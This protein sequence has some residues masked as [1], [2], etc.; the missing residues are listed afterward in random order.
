MIRVLKQSDIDILI[1]L[2]KTIRRNDKEELKNI[3][4]NMGVTKIL[5]GNIEDGKLTSM[6]VANLI[7]NNYYLEDIIFL[8]NDIDEV[9]EVMEYMVHTLKEDERGLNILYDNIPYSEVMDS[10]MVNLGFKCDYINFVS[11]ENGRIEL[12]RNHIVINDISED[13]NKYMLKCY[14]EEAELISKYLGDAKDTNDVDLS[15][16]NIAVAKDNIGNIIG[17]LRFGLIGSSIYIS[18]IYGD[19]DEVIVDL[20]NLVRN[21]TNRVIEIGIYPVR[22]ELINVLLNNGFKKAH[23][24]YKYKL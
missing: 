2:Y 15:K 1:D 12:I 7:K 21:L 17:M 23:A 19:T 3:Y 6:L 14:E 8:N 13:V 24:D 4:Y 22:T 9:K 18:N 10:I 16:T 11:E 5:V 20:I